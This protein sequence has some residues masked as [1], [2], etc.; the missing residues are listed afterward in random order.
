MKA[1]N[2]ANIKYDR[3]ERAKVR[4]SAVFPPDTKT[5]VLRT[6]RVVIDLKRN[7]DAL[8]TP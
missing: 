2:D 5:F 7:S 1:G 4:L 3:P 6:L 8:P